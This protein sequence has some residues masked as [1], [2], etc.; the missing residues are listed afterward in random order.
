[1]IQ[2]ARFSVEEILPLIGMGKPR[3]QLGGYSVKASSTRLECLKRN[4]T[5]VWC[6]RKGT[7]FVLEQ[8]EQGSPKGIN[9][10][11]EDCQWC[12]YQLAEGKHSWGGRPHLNLYHVNRKGGLLLMTQDHIM[13]RMHGGKD[14][15]EN[16]QTMCR[17][18]NQRKGSVIPKGMRK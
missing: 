13:P 3:I 6:H 15:I 18:C 5:C 11:I 12:Y 2:L 1:M 17:E 7:V 4:Q 10:F 14:V 9:C 8:H 16:L